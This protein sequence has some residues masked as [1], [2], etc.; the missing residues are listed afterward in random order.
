MNNYNNNYFDYIG[1]TGEYTISDYIDITSNNNFIYTSN[2]SNFLN[3]RIDD[4]DIETSN[5]SSNI[6]DIYTQK[7]RNELWEVN[8]NNSKCLIKSIPDYNNNIHTHIINQNIY[9][10][11]KFTNIY[12]GSN[13]RAVIDKFGKLNVYHIY[14]ILKPTIAEGW[15]DVE[16]EITN[17]ILLSQI[18]GAEIIVVQGQIAGIDASINFILGELTT[19]TAYNRAI[20]L[21]L[22]EEDE[23]KK[24]KDDDDDEE[25]SE[26]TGN[27]FIMLMLLLLTDLA[28]F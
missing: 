9:G 26:V 25:E 3:K 13:A 14:D 21:N 15:K 23:E 6:S 7:L 2:T 19:L 22:Q 16:G 18:N 24:R 17:L 10:E 27:R 4:I 20:N 11:I 1:A 5:I 12:T 28:E 8:P